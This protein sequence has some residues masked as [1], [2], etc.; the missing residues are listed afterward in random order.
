MAL[1]KKSI[2]LKSWLWSIVGGAVLCA[3]FWVVTDVIHI[4]QNLHSLTAYTDVFLSVSLFGN[5]VGAGLVLWRVTEN[6]YHDKTK[7]LLYRY[8]LLCVLSIVV[9]VTIIIVNTPLTLLILLW[10]LLPPMF[11]Y[12][13]IERLTKSQG[14][15]N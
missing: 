6:Y 9:G 15:I 8:T 2:F 10:S 4:L 14:A 7:R 5:V 3:I 12:K 1:T 13:L 11:I